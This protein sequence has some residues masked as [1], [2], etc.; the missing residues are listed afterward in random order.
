MS[1]TRIVCAALMLAAAVARADDWRG[2][3][4][5]S[6]RTDDALLID[7]M[8]EGDFSTRA[9]ICE[10]IARRSDPY[11]ADIIQFISTRITGT[12]TYRGEILLRILLA[13]LFD[14][15]RG[16]DAVRAALAA[17]ADVVSPMVARIDKWQDPQLRAVLVRLFPLMERDQVAGPLQEVGAGLVVAL[18]NSQ[19][20]LSPQSTALALD[21]LGSVET[22]RAGDCLDQCVQIARLSR[23]WERVDRAREVARQ[24]AARG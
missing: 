14:P 1:S 4:A 18:T 20:F 16:P 24:L 23:D 2:F 22:L 8:Q 13:G 15:S 11:A 9:S 6:D 5:R 3:A 7:I 12:G 10:G 17:N 19:G 21:F